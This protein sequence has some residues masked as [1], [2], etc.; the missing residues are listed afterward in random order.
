MKHIF[1]ILAMLLVFSGFLYA[2]EGPPPSQE[3][4]EG[5]TVAMRLRNV[6]GVCDGIVLTL[7]NCGKPVANRNVSLT[8][9][10][11]PVG[12]FLPACYPGSGF[13]YFTTTDEN[14]TMTITAPELCG[15]TQRIYFCVNYPPD[16]DK[17][18]CEVKGDFDITFS[19]DRS[20]CGGQCGITAACPCPGGE[21]LVNGQCEPCPQGQYSHNGRCVPQ[22][23]QATVAYVDQCGP[24]CPEGQYFNSDTGQC[25]SQCPQNTFANVNQCTP[26][27]PEGQRY[28]QGRCVSEC[29]VATV[30]YVEQCGP[31]C[32]QGQYFYNGR[33][34]SECPQNT[35]AYF[36]QCGPVCPEG[37]YYN[38][39][40]GQCVPQCPPTTALYVNQC[41]PACPEGQ[42]LYNGQ[43]VGQCPAA[44]V[45]YVDQC[46]PS[47]PQGQYFYNGRCTS[48]CPQNT[49][50]YVNQC[51]GCTANSDC[52]NGYTCDQTTHNC[53]P[54]CTSDA[55]C[56]ADKYCQAPVGATAAVGGTCQPVTGDCGQVVN[57]KWETY[58][59]A[60]GKPY[61]CGDEP[62]CRQCPQGYECKEHKCVAVPP[63]CGPTSAFVGDNVV[64]GCA[65]PGS[66]VTVTDPDGNQRTETAGD[67]GSITVRAE[68]SGNLTFRLAGGPPLNINVVPRSAPGEEGKETAGGEGT[69]MLLWFVLLLAIAI[70]AFLYWRMRQR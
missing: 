21:Q 22:C 12:C 20:L 63:L 69:P 62:G 37:Q 58:K 57:H 38:N 28:Y 50:A 59:T 7:T 5:C 17:V 46:G 42:Y 1:V 27:C 41:G 40:N 54:E 34:T 47:C 68:K 35:V 49:V 52:P 16:S 19:C 61:E 67:D 36:R 43:C 4:G 31:S 9:G 70:I 8:D 10:S 55:D 13:S 3:G 6:S 39:D 23:P 32:P 14:G 30:A 44:T 29:P 15:K 51:V 65:P 11:A 45:A 48:E 33:C 26:S 18:G 53:R 60:D 25:V 64:V 24:S 66:D 56:P 2:Q